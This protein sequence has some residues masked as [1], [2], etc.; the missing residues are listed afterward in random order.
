MYIP[1]GGL[2]FLCAARN[3]RRLPTRK[4]V[5]LEVETLERLHVQEQSARAAALFLFCK[6]LGNMPLKASRKRS[7]RLTPAGIPAGTPLLPPVA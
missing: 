4:P 5:V 7:S 3:L 6:K 1:L 2:S